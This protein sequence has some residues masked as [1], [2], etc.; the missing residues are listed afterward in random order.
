MV[1]LK[2]D[3]SYLSVCNTS[4]RRRKDKSA[5]TASPYLAEE[6][7]AIGKTVRVEVYV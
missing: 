2:I 1:I 6:K 3:G 5:E 7:W 4:R